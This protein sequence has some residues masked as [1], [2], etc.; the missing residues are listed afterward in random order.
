MSGLTVAGLIRPYRRQVS[1][2]RATAQP[3]S[4]TPSCPEAAITPEQFEGP[5]YLCDSP[6][7]SS[8][9]ESG[10]SGQRMILSGQ[11]LSV[12]CIPISNALVDFWQADASGNYDED[13]YRLRGHQFTDGEGRYQLETIIPGEYPGRTRHLHVKIQVPERPFFTTQLF[14]P[15][16][17]LNG[18]DRFFQPELTMSVVSS[19]PSAISSQAENL[20]PQ[21]QASFNFVLQP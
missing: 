5:F 19:E 8:L 12:N 7:R 17:P 13:G 11:V 3:L 18:D 1:H 21:Q 6:E 10:I 2:N 20:D 16:D 4:P 15:A 9:L 14:F